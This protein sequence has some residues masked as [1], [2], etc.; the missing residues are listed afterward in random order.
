MV[1]PDPLSGIVCHLY[2]STAGGRLASSVI[3]SRADV[4][5][6]EG[7]RGAGNAAVR[8]SAPDAAIGSRRGV[9]AGPCGTRAAL[10]S[11]Q[12]LFP[13]VLSCLRP[14]RRSCI[15]WFIHMR[16]GLEAILFFHRRRACFPSVLVN[17]GGRPPHMPHMCV[18]ESQLGIG[19]WLKS[20]IRGC[21]LVISVCIACKPYATF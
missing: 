7:G 9:A 5:G 2:G 1:H 13:R 14:P 20:L 15:Q 4:E 21:V 10:G 11:A 16:E 12:S 8:M 17:M 6:G 3:G 18:S 19:S